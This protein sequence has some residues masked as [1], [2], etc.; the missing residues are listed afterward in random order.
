MS[1]FRHG[2][3]FDSDIDAALYALLL[4]KQYERDG[5]FWEQFARDRGELACDVARESR[6]HS[7]RM[8]DKG[9]RVLLRLRGLYH[10]NLADFGPHIEKLADAFEEAKG[11]VNKRA[12]QLQPAH[13]T[14]FE[15]GMRLIAT[16][17]DL[18]GRK[19]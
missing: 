6:Q 16:A 14:F 17:P 4:A 8:E 15:K 1:N 7:R 19:R 2:I 3:R 12:I 10:Y 18:N 5:E 13:L 11:F 9:E